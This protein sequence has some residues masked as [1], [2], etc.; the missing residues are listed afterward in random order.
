MDKNSSTQV[1]QIPRI[2]DLDDHTGQL[3][4]YLIVLRGPAMGAMIRLNGGCVTVG[5]SPES[6]LQFGDPSISRHH[7]TLTTDGGRVKLVD[8]GSTNGTLL[9]G[10]RIGPIEM[11]ELSDGDRLQLGTS[12]LLKFA[13]PDA[14]EEKF[15]RELFDRSVRDPLTGLYNRGFFVDEVQSLYDRAATTGLGL[16]LILL[17][18]DHFKRVNDLHGHDAGDAALREVAAVLRQATRPDDLV[19]RYG[20]EEFVLALPV[21]GADSA[22]ERAEHL[23]K[24]VAARRIRLANGETLTL[25]ASL[26]LAYA[27]PDIPFD[28]QGLISLA[29]R[30]LY[31]AKQNG[32]NRVIILRKRR[33]PG[34]VGTNQSIT[35]EIENHREGTQSAATSQEH[36][37]SAEA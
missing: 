23:R 4:H 8:L 7:A 16:C 24:M 12:T 13:R 26:G 17:D 21:G 33:A 10:K 14:L 1:Y 29:D 6:L 15:C 35:L 34:P 36:P 32:R 25:T 22:I 18:I 2:A 37:R 30:A 19:A 28:S 11:I 20:G 31:H 27:S 9:N 5:R 3:R